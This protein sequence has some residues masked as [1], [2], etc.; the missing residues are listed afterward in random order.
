MGSKFISFLKNSSI[1]NLILF[2]IIFISLGVLLSNFTPKNKRFITLIFAI[3][4]LPVSVVLLSD[5]L[6]DL[7]YKRRRDIGVS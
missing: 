3:V 7:V 1:A 5:R 4:L 6:M 2:Q